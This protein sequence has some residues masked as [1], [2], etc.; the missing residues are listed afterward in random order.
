MVLFL[1]GP[2]KIRELSD[3]QQQ[4]ALANVFYSLIVMEDYAGFQYENNSKA[5]YKAVLPKLKEFGLFTETHDEIEY[6]ENTQLSV[7]AFL[8]WVRTLDGVT[9]YKDRT[10]KDVLDLFTTTVLRTWNNTVVT[11]TLENPERCI[12]Y[13]EQSDGLDYSVMSRG[14]VLGLLEPLGIKRVSWSG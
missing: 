1:Q 11:G 8:W 13:F 2:R 14:L 9:P 12:K 4:T 7:D 10:T 6:I 5:R 3:E